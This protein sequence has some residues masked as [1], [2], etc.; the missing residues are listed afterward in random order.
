MGWYS[1]NTGCTP[2]GATPLE[3]CG[4]Q[5]SNDVCGIMLYTNMIMGILTVNI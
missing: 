1:S 3:S 5:H 4:V 2:L